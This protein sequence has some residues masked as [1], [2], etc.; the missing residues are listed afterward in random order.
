MSGSNANPAPGSP[1]RTVPHGPRVAGVEEAVA[2]LL[3]AGA[4]AAVVLIVAGVVLMV[5]QGVN[6]LS[7]EF[8]ALNLEGLVP[9]MLAL[10]PAA[11]IWAGVLVVVATPIAMV[12]VELTA[13]ARRHDARMA[14]LAIGILG[15][16]ALSVVSAILLER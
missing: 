9:S 8:P 1:A 3:A 12:T 4:V 15:I 2:R 16:I 13:F 5:A 10:E 6:P 7:R 11:F 14:L